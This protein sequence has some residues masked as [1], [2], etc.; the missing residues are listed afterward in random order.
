MMALILVYTG[1]VHFQ[2]QGT[3]FLLGAVGFGD[4]LAPFVGKWLFPYKPY[5]IWNSTKTFSGSCTVFLGTMVG[6]LVLR[7]IL[8][9]PEIIDPKQIGVIAFLATFTEAVS[10][11]WDNLAIAA[12]IELY[13]RVSELY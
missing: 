7:G 10:G 9:A 2:S 8:G 1:L 11:S 6:I 5:T 13:L 3:T 4:G 12:S